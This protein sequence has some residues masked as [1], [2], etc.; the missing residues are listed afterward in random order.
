MQIRIIILTLCWTISRPSFKKITH[1]DEFGPG[2]LIAESLMS[3]LVQLAVPPWLSAG[4]RLGSVHFV[5][6]I[7]CT[8]FQL[9]NLL[10]PID[11]VSL[12]W[13]GRQG[14]PSDNLAILD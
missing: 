9:E 1:V 7:G 5:L 14:Y 12:H 6:I 10:L 2:A 13:K 4:R 11:C 8:I 3:M